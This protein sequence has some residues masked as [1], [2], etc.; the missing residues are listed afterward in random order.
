MGVATAPS[1]DGP[2]TR[3][4][5]GEPVLGVDA[6]GGDP[7]NKLED[8]QIWR[9]TRG[10]QMLLHQEGKAEAPYV[11]AHAYSLDNGAPWTYAGAAYDLTVFDSDGVSTTFSRR[12]RPQLPHG[13]DGAPSHLFNGVEDADGDGYTQTVAVPLGT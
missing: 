8:L 13:P 12:E 4:N 2:F 9:T 10:I 7:D 6:E 5:G 3:L 1:W 11:G